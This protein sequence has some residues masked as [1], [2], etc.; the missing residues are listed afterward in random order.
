MAIDDGFIAVD[1]Y[2][3]IHT[4]YDGPG[5]QNPDFDEV[6]KPRGSGIIS[7]ASWAFEILSSLCSLATLSSIIIILWMTNGKPVSDWT[8]RISL[9][10]T[11]AILST[12]SSAALMH[13][14]SSFISQLKWLYF[15]KEPRRLH[16]FELF[17]EASRGPYGSIIF[18]FGVKWNLATIGAF[19]TIFRLASSP[20]IQQA[21][22]LKTQNA[23]L[24]DEEATLGYAQMYMRDL[25]LDSNVSPCK[26]IPK[27]FVGSRS[28]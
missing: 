18:L 8:F 21:I 16:Q 15:K 28:D 11:I 20:L 5:P 17:D 4:R 22:Q 25:R 2:K 12:I 26:F 19:I 10:A 23:Y 13:N 14:V 3:L 27:L 6:D 9:S 7:R 1:E 24:A